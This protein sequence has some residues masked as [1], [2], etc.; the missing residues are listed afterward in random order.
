MHLY[1]FRFT[2]GLSTLGV[3]DA[4]RAHPAEMEVLF[5]MPKAT[6]FTV[7]DLK[8]MTT[9]IF[10]EEHSNRHRDEQETYAIWLDFIEQLDGSFHLSVI[11]PNF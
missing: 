11:K 8:A 10:S 7:E 5:I 6:L 4:I 2:E 3:L 1:I 9:V